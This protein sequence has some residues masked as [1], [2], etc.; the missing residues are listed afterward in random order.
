MK[1]TATM[2]KSVG[3]YFRMEDPS[4]CD[5]AKVCEGGPDPDV[6]GGAA[7]GPFP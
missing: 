4:P 6:G 2:H 3:K 7:D 5:L 1:G